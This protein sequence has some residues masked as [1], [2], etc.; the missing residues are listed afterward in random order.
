MIISRK[1][2]TEI[3][4]TVAGCNTRFWS[5]RLLIHVELGKLG[6][7][8]KLKQ[9]VLFLTMSQDWENLAIAMYTLGKPPSTQQNPLK[10]TERWSPHFELWCLK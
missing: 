4:Q 9:H 5:C 10:L 1:E 7:G 8:K 2:E 6:V 3:Q